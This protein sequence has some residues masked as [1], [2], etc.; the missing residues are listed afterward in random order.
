VR[1]GQGYT[2]LMLVEESRLLQI[3]IFDTLRLNQEKLNP[4]KV[5]SDVMTIADECDAQLKDTM[6][7]LLV[8]EKQN[9]RAVA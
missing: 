4:V 3:S 6:E 7:T 8:L 2:A 5:L 9:K 1:H